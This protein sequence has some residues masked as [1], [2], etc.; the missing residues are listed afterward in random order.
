MT[1]P[2]RDQVWY[3]QPLFYNSNFSIPN[4][5]ASPFRR[6]F[7]KK[8]ALRKPPS[9]AVD[10][11]T[12][13]VPLS[14]PPLLPPSVPPWLPL[15]PLHLPSWVMNCLTNP[16]DPR[17]RN[18]PSLILLLLL[19]SSSTPRM[20]CRGFWRLFSRLELLFSLPL[21]FLLLFPLP[22]PLQLALL[23]RHPGR[24]WRPVPRTYTAES[25][26]CIA[27]TSVSNV[28]SILL[29]LELRDLP[30]FFLPRSSCGTGSAFAGSSTSKDMTPKPPSRLPGTNLRHSSAIAWVTPKPF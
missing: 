24:S 8:L 17:G 9:K 15:I 6:V 10:V 18:T 22:L 16:L 5:S 26:I 23:P 20:T 11:P 14:L 2:A 4:K 25:P 7:W 3:E 1:K 19:V 21:L 13:S 28:R 30:E 12:M 29:S 27:K